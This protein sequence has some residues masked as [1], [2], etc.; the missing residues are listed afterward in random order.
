[1]E[2]SKPDGT[3][4]PTPAFGRARKETEEGKRVVAGTPLCHNVEALVKTRESKDQVLLQ[5][6][7]YIP[8]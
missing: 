2:H 7:S 3:H 6:V 1:M 5:V 4:K 8:F